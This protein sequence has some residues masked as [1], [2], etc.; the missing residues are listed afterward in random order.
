M[1]FARKLWTKEEVEACV[2]K[3]PFNDRIEDR[4][5]TDEEKKEFE[6]IETALFDSD[7]NDDIYCADYWLGETIDGKIIQPGA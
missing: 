3:G 2:A 1:A 4:E 7:S 5:L 6:R